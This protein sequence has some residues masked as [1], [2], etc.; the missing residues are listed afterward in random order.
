MKRYVG[1]IGLCLVMFFLGFIFADIVS[2]HTI[3]G[4]TDEGSVDTT[5]GI[6]TTN[7]TLYTTEDTIEATEQETVYIKQEKPDL[8]RDSKGLDNRMFYIY[9][10]SGYARDSEVSG[11]IRWDMVYAESEAHNEWIEE[12]T[13][14]SVFRYDDWCIRTG[15]YKESGQW[16]VTF[17][18]YNGFK[19]QMISIFQTIGETL[20]YYEDMEKAFIPQYFGVPNDYSVEITSFDETKQTVTLTFTSPE[21]ETIEV[22]ITYEKQ[23]RCDE[24]GTALL[25]K[26]GNNFLFQYE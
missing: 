7:D 23:C 25:D 12:Q 4:Q 24:N 16:T 26:N 1:I 6:C 11:I 8:L 3:K 14:N 13:F 18:E 17:F 5:D 19:Q 2:P 21:G 15:Y 9:R 10:T 22:Y 20:S